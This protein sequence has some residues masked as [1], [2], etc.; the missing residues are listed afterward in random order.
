MSW[1]AGV[2]ASQR[3]QSE[4]RW[5]REKILLDGE[6]GIQWFREQGEW[7]NWMLRGQ[8]NKKKDRTTATFACDT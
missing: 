1:V 2:G 6:G 3:R 4:S 5:S 8:D 7:S